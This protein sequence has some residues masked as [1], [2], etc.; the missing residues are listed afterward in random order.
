MASS[1]IDEMMRWVATNGVSF[2]SK[3]TE[4]MHFSRSKLRAAPSVCHGDIEKYPE[5]ALHWLGIWL[6]S[7]LSFRVYVKK[8]AAKAQAVAYHLRGL[9]NTKHG[10]LLAAV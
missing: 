2:D 4:V 9:T 8:W 6:D 10:P 1:S 3:K 5:S 7:R